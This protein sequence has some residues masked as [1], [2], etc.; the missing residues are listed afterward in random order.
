VVSEIEQFEWDLSV[1]LDK[2]GSLQKKSGYT[3]RIAPLSLD[4]AGRIKK[5]EDKLRRTTRDLRKRIA[6]RF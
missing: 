3:R 5:S 4:A 2:G 6:E 1:G